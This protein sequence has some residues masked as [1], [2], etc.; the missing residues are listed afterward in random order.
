[1][2]C[3]TTSK[4]RASAQELPSLASLGR[5]QAFFGIQRLYSKRQKLS[6]YEQIQY[7]TDMELKL[8]KLR[9]FCLWPCCGAIAA[10]V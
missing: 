4:Q 3:T 7:N 5:L 2:Q 1:M 6:N 10:P 8:P 9:R